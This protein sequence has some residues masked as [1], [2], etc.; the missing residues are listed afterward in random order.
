[1]VDWPSSG[2]TPKPDH[3][4]VLYRRARLVTSLVDQESEQQKSQMSAE[5]AKREPEETRQNHQHNNL[6]HRNERQLK[7]G[8]GRTKPIGK[9][10]KNGG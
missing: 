5:E 8:R 10:V 1:M 2:V 3:P 9:H 4:K 7:G 6:H